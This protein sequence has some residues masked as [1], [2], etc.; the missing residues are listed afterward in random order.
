MLRGTLAIADLVQQ[1]PV[2]DGKDIA[3]GAS[4]VQILR[5]PALESYL[6][7]ARPSR[8][9]YVVRERASEPVEDG[10]GASHHTTRDVDRYTALLREALT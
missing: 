7:D 1:F 4:G 10:H 3:L 6:V 9:F 8:W 5:V 2:F